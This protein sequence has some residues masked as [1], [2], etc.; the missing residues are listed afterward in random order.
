MRARRVRVRDL[1][2]AVLLSVMCRLL[3][4]G[5]AVPCL[6]RPTCCL[7]A[8]SLTRGQSHRATW[9][10]L[11]ARLRGGG[12][13]DGGGGGVG[14]GLGVREGSSMLDMSRGYAHEGAGTFAIDSV[15]AQ[16]Q[17]AHPLRPS[18]EFLG[19]EAEPG[20]VGPGG[21]GGRAS[22]EG[23]EATV[24]IPDEAPSLRA[25][26]RDTE[27]RQGVLVALEDEGDERGDGNERGSTNGIDNVWTVYKVVQRV[28][29]DHTPMPGMQD[30][31]LL[32]LVCCVCVHTHTHTQ[33]T[34]TQH[35]HTQVRT[36]S[37]VVC[38]PGISIREGPI[39]LLAD[40]R[41]SIG[42]AK[43]FQRVRCTFSKVL[44]IHGKFTLHGKCT[45][46]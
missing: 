3:C 45:R 40:S 29:P 9:A 5:V 39:H 32:V 19:A 21:G 15:G 33:H 44:S 24:T 7:P 1:A 37:H 43:F 25:A 6:L 20:S 30:S 38:S 35:T 34:H 31:K 14:G 42:G 11:C 10:L 41:G 23:A 2:R 27:R 8:P 17:M 28:H 12:S 46:R 18:Q 13:S 36:W 22:F 26:L 16:L 4:S